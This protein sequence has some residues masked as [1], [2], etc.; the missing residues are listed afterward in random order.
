MAHPATPLQPNYM[1]VFIQRDYSEGT[2]VKF[3]NRFP[4]ELESRIDRHTFE[5]TINKLNEYFIEAEKGNCSTYCAG[6]LACLTAYLIYIFTETHYEKCLRKV[7]K[8]IANQN[9]RVY[10]PIGLHIT[11]PVNRGLRVIEISIIDRP[12]LQQT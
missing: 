1:K 12:V 8:Y 5:S 10:N 7:S 2:S 3:Q 9:E 4:S 6:L 11:D